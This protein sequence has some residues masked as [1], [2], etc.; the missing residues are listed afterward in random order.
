[1][2]L[3]RYFIVLIIF[4]TTLLVAIS[5]YRLYRTK[6]SH[7]PFTCRT[8]LT[9]VNDNS[10]VKVVLKF[11][12]KKGYGTVSINGR[13]NDNDGSTRVVS[14]MIYFIFKQDGNFYPLTSKNIVKL[15][16]DN[17]DSAWMEKYFPDFYH[18]TEQDLYMNIL[19]QGG[20]N[21]IFVDPI[22]LLVCKTVLPGQ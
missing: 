21:I 4:L 9:L 19:S 10:S 8:W 2:K 3:N 7:H 14:R 22:P 13:E 20:N 16:D 5:T 1:M 11:M 6:E 18:K 15:P 17:V 12:F